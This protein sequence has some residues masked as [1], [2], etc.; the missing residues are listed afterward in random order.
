MSNAGD[1]SRNKGHFRRRIWRTNGDFDMQLIMVGASHLEHYSLQN[2]PLPVY[3][4]VDLGCFSQATSAGSRV[5]QEH[6]ATHHQESGIRA[7]LR[8]TQPKN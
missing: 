3:L 2:G 6:A 1:T 4:S 8:P 7:A 5:S